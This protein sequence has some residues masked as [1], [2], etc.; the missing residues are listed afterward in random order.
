VQGGGKENG[1]VI[2]SPKAEEPVDFDL[3]VALLAHL[4]STPEADDGGAVVGGAVLVFLPGFMEIEQVVTRIGQHPLLGDPRRAQAFPLHST[5]PPEA[6]RGV[7]RRMPRGVRKIVVATNIAET[8]I[9]I[10]DVT[11]VI[12]AGRVKETRYDPSTHMSS[13]VAVWTSQASA[14][15]RA[16]RAGRVREG[17]CWRL[18]TRQFMQES[19]PEYTLPEMLRTPVSH[20]PTRLP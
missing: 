11:H 7:F 19:M 9:T 8:S 6:Q 18:Y 12:D 13:L 10:D 20:L 5:L 17:H 15:Q 4:V 3:I 1:K 2:M 14:S 16:G